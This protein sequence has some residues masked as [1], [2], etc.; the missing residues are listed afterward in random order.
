[1]KNNSYTEE[2]CNKCGK[3]FWL[4][5]KCSCDAKNTNKVDVSK[6]EHQSSWGKCY[7]SADGEV[8]C[9]YIENCYFKQ[10]SAKEER[11]QEILAENEKYK[12]A[13]EKIV[14][15]RVKPLARTSHAALAQ[16][17]TI[18]K[19]ALEEQECEK[20]RQRELYK[21]RKERI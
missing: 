8:E 20:Q 5:N 9:G 6:C 4:P 3:W 16:A 14:D 2:K 11:T 19:Q 21:L 10:L 12:E 15:P 1:M 7:I 17:I 18:A 13:L